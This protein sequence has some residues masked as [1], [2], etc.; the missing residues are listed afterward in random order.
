[1]GWKTTSKLVM[2]LIVIAFVIGYYVLA[3][4]GYIE[5]PKYWQFGTLPVHI[6]LIGMATILLY[7]VFE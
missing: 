5:L 7:Q 3:G 4:I 2:A 1:M 6:F